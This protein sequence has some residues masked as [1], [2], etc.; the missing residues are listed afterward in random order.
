MR[1]FLFVVAAMGLTACAT[2]PT[3][4][5]EKPEWERIGRI[6]G[7][8]GLESSNFD[9]HLQTCERS[10]TVEDQV[11]YL[12]GWK[13]GT[14]EFC[15]A[16]NGYEAGA[17]SLK[18]NF[19]C[20]PQK[21]PEFMEQFRL[22]RKVRELKSEQQRISEKIEERQ[23]DNGF[24][25][26]TFRAMSLLSGQDP[27]GDLK[28][29]KREIGQ[30]IDILEKDAAGRSDA[31]S[32]LSY[33]M[34]GDGKNYFNYF[35]AIMGTFGGFGIGHAFQGRYMDDGWKWTL[36]EFAALGTMFATADDCENRKDPV[37]GTVTYQC[38]RVNPWALVGWLGF[39]VWQSYD[40]W[41]Y[42]NGYANKV[43]VLPTQ[44]GVTVGFS[45]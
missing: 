29:E 11:L 8:R 42:A 3:E 25:P 15:T 9:S 44:E 13:Q 24:F 39:R 37:T 38:N 4:Q 41:H 30:K 5:C 36:G 19:G 22:G 26:Q 20:D 16:K 33:Q 40:L 23:N 31:M 10:A 14:V 28:N 35:G 1:S 6:D 18:S 7:S 32:A 43:Y 17:F 27:D 34:E 12:K 45:F 21:Y 2:L